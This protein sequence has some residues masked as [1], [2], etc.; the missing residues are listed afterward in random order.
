VASRTGVATITGTITCTKPGYVSTTSGQLTQKVSRYTVK[1][2]LYVYAY[3][4]GALTFSVDVAGDSGPFVG[5]KA[6]ASLGILGYD[7][8]TGEFD[9]VA[10][11]RTL[12]LKAGAH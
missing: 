7:S 8:D 4:L 3:C 10:A 12:V 6:I 11:S 1:G 9:Q 5:G 2:P